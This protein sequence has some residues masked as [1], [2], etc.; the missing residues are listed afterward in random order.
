MLGV[1]GASADQMQHCHE[2]ACKQIRTEQTDM[3]LLSKSRVI[4]GL[5]LVEPDILKN[6]HL[7]VLQNADILQAV[8]RD[9]EPSQHPQHFLI[10]NAVVCLEYLRQQRRPSSKAPCRSMDKHELIWGRTFVPSNSDK[11][12][13]TGV[14][15]NLSSGPSLG[16]PYKWTGI[17]KPTC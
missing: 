16:R 11:R 10:T 15:R 1:C 17:C 8:L 2:A 5:L 14:R 4:F 6:E 12:G 7:H 13:T 3:Y 9:W